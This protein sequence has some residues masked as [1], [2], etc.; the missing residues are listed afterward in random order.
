MI[1]IL[2]CAFKFEFECVS[3]RD[4]PFLHLNMSIP[5][6]LADSSPY[7]SCGKGSGWGS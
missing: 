6:L 7:I 4:C 5:F 1:V 3:Q 2:Q